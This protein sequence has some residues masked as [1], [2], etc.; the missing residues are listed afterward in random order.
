MGNLQALFG[1][2]TSAYRTELRFLVRT[3]SYPLLHLLWLGLLFYSF[4]G[5]F[6]DDRSAY[7]LLETSLGRFTIGMTS[8]VALFVAG[9]I[10]T[11]SMG[12]MFA[13]LEGTLPTGLETLLG[14]WL[15]GITAVAGFLLEPLV[16]A[17]YQGPVAS[18]WAGLPIFVGEAVLTIAFTSA[19]AWWL[20]SRLK[21]GRW[22]YPLLAAGWMVLF[23]APNMLYS[24][25]QPLMLLNF[26]RQGTINVFSELYGRLIYGDLFL[27]FNL[28]Y[29]GLLMMLLGLIAGLQSTR[30]FHRWSIKAGGVILAALGVAAFAGWGY[31]TTVRAGE[32]QAT[33]QWSNNRFMSPSV[34]LVEP[35]FIVEEYDLKLDLSERNHPLLRVRMRVH[36]TDSDPLGHLKFFLYPGFDI[37]ESNLSTERQ[38][39]LLT[40]WLTEALQPGESH[41]IQISYSGRVW[42]TEVVRGTPVAIDFVHPDGVRLSP[43]IGWYPLPVASAQQPYGDLSSLKPARVHLKVNGVDGLNFGSNLP[44]VGPG[45]FHSEDATWIFLFGSPH[46]VEQQIDKT[47]LITARNDLPR[48]LD[49]VHIYSDV[50]DKMLPFFPGLEVEGLTLLVLGEESGLPV[51]T[52]PSDNQ[53]VVVISRWVLAGIHKQGPVNYPQYMVWD[54]LMYDLW[55]LFT[56]QPGSD[57]NWV[58]K[59]ITGF[60]WAYHR[61][62][63]IAEMMKSLISESHS[64][65]LALTEVYSRHGFEGVFRALDKMRIHNDE[66]QQMEFQQFQEW[67]VELY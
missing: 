32:E 55:E 36:N 65:G 66:I 37:V 45:E 15:A 63:G 52:P 30:R 22:A 19:V 47:T 57:S 42:R 24:I 67:I 34:E 64:A 9:I 54:A 62:D 49:L 7:V 53:L 51:N 38:G 44:K 48:V 61:V 59:E 58:V 20:N 43:G 16:V 29:L 27:Y 31:M 13:E 8:L 60:V 25:Y 3:W 56:G 17:A 50:F 33:G 1:R 6:P 35:A 41:D 11:R 46:L 39:E 26:M 12:L 40:F 4:V 10:A 23:L 21:L 5:S 2:F 14:R 18:L 28:F